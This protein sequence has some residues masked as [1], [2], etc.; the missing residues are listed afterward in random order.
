MLVKITGVFE[1]ESDNEDEVNQ[2]FKRQAVQLLFTYL[3]TMVS[4][5][6]STALMNSLLIPIINV[7]DIEEIENT[8]E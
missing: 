8:E 6:T 7:T 5:V 4:N 2:F 3:R 1:F